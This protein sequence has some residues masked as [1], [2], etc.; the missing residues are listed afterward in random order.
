MVSDGLTGLVEHGAD[1]TAEE[2][3]CDDGD[4]G[5]ERQDQCVFGEALA[6]AVTSDQRDECE[7][8]RHEGIRASFPQDSSAEAE[9]APEMKDRR[10]RMGTGGSKIAEVA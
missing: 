10:H 3:Q 9:G 8:L 2:E 5:D 4:H 7:K 1:L 6:P